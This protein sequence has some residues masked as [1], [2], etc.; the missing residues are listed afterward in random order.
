MKNEQFYLDNHFLLLC[1]GKII[2]VAINRATV[3]F[4]EHIPVAYHY[5]PPYSLSR[6]NM[7]VSETISIRH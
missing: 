3:L 4:V 6:E 5:I 1:P 7:A 2:K